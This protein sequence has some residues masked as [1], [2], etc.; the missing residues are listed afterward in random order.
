MYKRYAV[1]K[2]WGV[3]V[4]DYNQNSVGG[5]KSMVFELKGQDVFNKMKY[6]SGVHRVQRVPATETAGRV[7]TSTA[8][9][10]VLPEA[11]DVDV[12]IDPSDL[13]IDVFIGPKD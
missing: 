4:I 10:A 12:S 2:G 5:Y 6:E 9:V 1:I 11:K 8:T 13:R 3:E 7:H